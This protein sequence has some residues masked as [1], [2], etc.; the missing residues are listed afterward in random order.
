MVSVRFSFCVIHTKIIIFLK[1]KRILFTLH[2]FRISGM[3]LVKEII[4][5]STQITVNNGCMCVSVH[6]F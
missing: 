3:P 6:S 2:I 5:S 4:I 1:N